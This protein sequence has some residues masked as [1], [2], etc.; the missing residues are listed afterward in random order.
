MSKTIGIQ[1]ESWPYSKPTCIQCGA[2]LLANARIMRIGGPAGDRI[3]VCGKTCEQAWKT[4][5]REKERKYA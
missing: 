2:E 3:H 4:E 1:I 5:Y